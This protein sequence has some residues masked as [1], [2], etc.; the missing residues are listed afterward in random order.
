VITIHPQQEVPYTLRIEDGPHRLQIR[1][2][3]DAHVNRIKSSKKALEELEAIF[4]E[5]NGLGSN[6]GISQALIDVVS[7]PVKIH[8]DWLDEAQ[9]LVVPDVQVA[10][11]DIKTTTGLKLRL[12]SGFELHMYEN[13]IVEALRIEV[14]GQSGF[15][16]FTQTAIVFWLQRPFVPKD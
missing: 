6:Y 5:V 12:K 16:Y 2:H 3:L 15:I 1:S 7:G 4:V 13:R 8:K 11:D 14:W 9:V 10:F